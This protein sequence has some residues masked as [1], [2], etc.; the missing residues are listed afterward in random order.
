ML[1]QRL[2]VCCLKGQIKSVAA[3]FFQ[4]SLVPISVNAEKT[5]YRVSK[6]TPA[7]K[8]SKSLSMYAASK[9]S[10]NISACRLCLDRVG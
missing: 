1:A 3:Y 6:L 5:R 4:G 7:R 8:A 10:A 2:L 9:Y